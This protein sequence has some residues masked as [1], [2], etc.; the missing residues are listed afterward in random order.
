[1]Q[2]VTIHDVNYA[3]AP[4]GHTKAM[5][6]GQRIVVPAAARSADRVI[7]GSAHSRATVIAH[8]GVAPGRIDVVPHG[9]GRPPGPA[10]PER[11]LRAKLG[12][13]DA[14]FILCFSARR[15]HKNLSR[16][17]AAVA[18]MR[19][20]P[21]P[22]LV[23]P[24]YRT[25][26]DAEL[27]TQARELGI[28]D[29]VRLLDWVDDADL[30]GLYAAARVFA[31]PSLAEGFGLPVLEAMARGVPVACSDASSLPEV[32]GDAARY[33]DP[34][35]V[36]SIAA[37][38]DELLT[39]RSVASRLAAAGRAQAAIFTWQRAARGTLAT[40]ERALSLR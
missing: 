32:G 35:D 27:A 39:D 8:L 28:A 7:T 25:A 23:L 30:E 18:R 22:T 24:G 29:R 40:Y 2:V 38:L 12:L 11:E 10:T 19:A 16:L 6:Y 17:V 1:V 37:A 15:P 13:G 31:F 9:G 20:Q 36:D 26:F 14:P 4:E 3:V 5:L 21:A 34:F 33:F